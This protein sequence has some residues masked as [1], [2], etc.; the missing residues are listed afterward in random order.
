MELIY[1]ALDIFIPLQSFI[2]DKI[3]FKH[4]IMKC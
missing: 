3:E 4:N 1:I 2:I